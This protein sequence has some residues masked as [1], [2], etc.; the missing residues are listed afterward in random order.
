MHD[1]AAIGPLLGPRRQEAIARLIE[2]LTAK[3]ATACRVLGSSAAITRLLVELLCEVSTVAASSAELEDA[4]DD[5]DQSSAAGADVLQAE[6]AKLLKSAFAAAYGSSWSVDELKAAGLLL[7]DLH[8][9]YYITIMA[10]TSA[11]HQTDDL[12]QPG[13]STSTSRSASKI[14]AALLAATECLESVMRTLSQNTGTADWL[15][16][17][18]ADLALQ[19]KQHLQLFGRS[20]CMQQGLA[21]SMLQAPVIAEQLTCDFE[22]FE[23]SSRAHAD[24]NQAG[25]TGAAQ[26]AELTGCLVC[27][28]CL[29]AGRRAA[30]ALSNT[31]T[32]Y[33]LAF[34]VVVTLVLKSK[35]PALKTL[36]GAAEAVLM[37]SYRYHAAS[38]D[39][40][41]TGMSPFLT[42][43]SKDVSDL[44]SEMV[45]ATVP[46][47]VALVVFAAELHYQLVK[48]YKPATDEH[49]W[50][51][52][53]LR[54]TAIVQE[55]CKLGL[56]A[57]ADAFMEKSFLLANVLQKTAMWVAYAPDMQ[58][59]DAGLG[60]AKDQE[61]IFG[62]VRTAAGCLVRLG[63]A[64]RQYQAA[65]EEMQGVMRGLVQFGGQP[66]AA[67]LDE[68]T[69]R[70]LAAGGGPAAM[71]S[72]GQQGFMA[73]A[74]TP[75][76]TSLKRQPAAV[77]KGA[78]SL[79]GPSTAAAAAP[80]R[81]PSRQVQLPHHSQGRAAGRQPLLTSP[82]LYSRETNPDPRATSTC[83]VPSMQTQLQHHRQDLAAR[84]LPLITSPP[85]YSGNSSAAGT[86]ADNRQQAAQLVGGTAGSADP[87]QV[88]IG[89]VLLLLDSNDTRGLSVLGQAARSSQAR[90]TQ[91]AGHAKVW[92]AMQRYWETATNRAA[93]LEAVVVLTPAL[94]LERN[95]EIFKKS[96]VAQIM[97]SSLT[98]SSNTAAH[99]VHASQV[100]RALLSGEKAQRAIQ[101]LS[102]R[103]QWVQDVT[104]AVCAE[105]APAD[106][107]PH[108]VQLLSKLCTKRNL[109]S[110]VASVGY[111]VCHLQKFLEDA[112]SAVRRPAAVALYE[113]ASKKTGP[114]DIALAIVRKPGAIESLVCKLDD[115][116]THVARSCSKCLCAVAGKHATKLALNVCGHGTSHETPRGSWKVPDQVLRQLMQHMAEDTA[117]G[118][119]AT[120]VVGVLVCST[121]DEELHWDLQSRQVH[122]RLLHALEPAAQ[123]KRAGVKKHAALGLLGMSQ[124]PMV[125]DSLMSHLTDTTRDPILHSMAQAA[126]SFRQPPAFL[127]KLR[128]EWKD[129]QA[130][131]AAVMSSQRATAAGSSP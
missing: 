6:L 58:M 107:L 18:I 129:Y 47:S 77:L 36:A 29:A 118:E 108:L 40:G 122:H 106:A 84:R 42:G 44:A 121:A 15:W 4:D 68:I 62:A 57:S 24:S 53:V 120:C 87:I 99:E 110:R 48:A 39:N 1:T 74:A 91:L 54:V 22:A 78:V 76:S 104:L 73:A 111:T 12:A 31:G 90:C 63:M 8:R 3:D 5:H 37:A 115:K 93:V 51:Q 127:N 13:P 26:R 55:M 124:V 100:L 17:S 30:G 27:Q 60:R 116:D 7:V 23:P 130:A 10:S 38:N 72:G 83:R 98:Q 79:A 66:P 112:R 82:P 89:Q 65:I 19:S 131:E 85:L 105:D 46:Q 75:P 123:L 35:E 33:I 92:A 126:L 52:G 103:S 69:S 71:L 94:N 88:S 56:K 70:P 21:I 11:D 20:L 34:R 9:Q 2:S 80:S 50:Q 41:S 28:L 96:Q 49:I 45:Q 125:R 67:L 64:N 119:A 102:S 113:L 109:A 97:C 61:K 128:K 16:R 101:K 86:K 81:L 95:W 32:M 14:S 117:A 114:H 59:S 25:N 43:V